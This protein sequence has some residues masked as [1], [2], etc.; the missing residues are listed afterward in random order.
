MV[1]LTLDQKKAL[2]AVI[3]KLN[4]D[5]VAALKGYAGTGKTTL[6]KRI[7][8]EMRDRSN[9][10]YLMAPTHKAAE[11]L[12]KKAHRDV[13]TVHSAFGLRPVWDGKGGY[14]FKRTGEKPLSFIYNSFIAVDEASMVDNYLYDLLYEAKKQYNL[15][16]LFVG[17]P[18]QL[19]P[20]N[21][22]PSKALSHSGYTLTE[23]I[24][25]ANDNPIL[26][27]SEN[28][29]GMYAVDH[30]F[31]HDVDDRGRGVYLLKDMNDFI[32]SAIESFMTE[33][34]KQTGDH[35]RILAYRNETV[36]MYNDIVRTVLYGENSPQFIPG[37]WLVAKEPWYVEKQLSAIIQNSEEFI[38]VSA[39]ESETDGWKTWDL[40][41]SSGPSSNKIK[42]ITVLHKD[43]QKRY[44]KHLN[45]LMDEA[46]QK[47]WKWNQYYE[48]KE[49]FAVVDYSFALTTHKAQ[50]STFH[51]TFM[52]LEDINYCRKK[53]ERHS[54]IYVA[55]TRPSEKLKVLLRY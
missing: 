43:D 20:V 48:F 34:H 6:M 17:D 22:K 23:V 33:E 46:K 30:K 26:D 5:G 8:S 50:G 19:P 52:D 14:I 12:R 45:R 31:E 25:Q 39:K 54:L 53:A 2:D 3:T 27:L 1:E 51:T 36:N 18:A 55:S 10:I 40:E 44:D 32:E 21:E 4:S 41:V 37:E 49:K 7:V 38:V 16:L 11:V 15:K 42:E 9:E 24:R 47:E 13:T 35:A 29:R 28:L